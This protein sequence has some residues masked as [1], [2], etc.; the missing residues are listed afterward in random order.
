MLWADRRRI[1]WWTQRRAA[2][3]WPWVAV[4]AVFLFV[5]LTNWAWLRT[6]VVT[7]GWDRIAHLETSLLYFD[8]LRDLHPRTLFNA[9]TLEGYYPPLVHLLAVG[10]YHLFGRSS[11]VAAATMVV[12]LLVLLLAV[13][14]IAERLWGSLVGVL[15]VVLLALFPMIFALSRYL[16]LDFPLTAAVAASIAALLHTGRFHRRAPS[17]LFG[18]SLG[19]GFL[20]KWSFAFFLVAPVALTLLV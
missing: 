15:T 19:L 4:A 7:L 8:V 17:L 9:W 10:A 20:T 6:N 2:V 1:G 5:A 18:L 3:P 12:W 16:Y 11:D 14:S 13:Y